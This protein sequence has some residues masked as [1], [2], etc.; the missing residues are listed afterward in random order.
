MVL[1]GFS[2]LLWMLIATLSRSD[3]AESRAQWAMLILSLTTAACLLL[4]EYQGGSIWG[5]TY[6]PKPLALLCIGFAFMARLNIK[7][8]NISQ[9][10]NP[11]Q[12]MKENK[13]AL[14]EE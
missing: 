7:G 2:L 8:K 6:L 14:E 11:H 5:S 13:L 1:C 3:L 12:I 10:M 9:G 4:L